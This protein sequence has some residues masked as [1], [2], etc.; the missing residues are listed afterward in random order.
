MGVIKLAARIP[1]SL[2]LLWAYG[3]TSLHI[4]DNL[5][6]TLK[7]IIIPFVEVVL[8]RVFGALVG[9]RSPVPLVANIRTTFFTYP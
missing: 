3:K 1:A 7:R 9:L 6:R 8:R 5:K 2:F 4:L